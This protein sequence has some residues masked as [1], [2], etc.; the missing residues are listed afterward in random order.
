[1][2]VAGVMGGGYD[3]DLDQLV[4]RHVLLHVAAREL[5]G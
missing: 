4:A 3:D 2:P 1:V 5:F